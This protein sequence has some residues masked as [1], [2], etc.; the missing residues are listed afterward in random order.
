LTRPFANAAFR[1]FFP[2]Y[3]VQSSLH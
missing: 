1:T 3:P 2:L